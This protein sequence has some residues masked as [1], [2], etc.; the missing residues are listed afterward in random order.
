MGI[1][2]YGTSNLRS[3]QKAGRLGGEERGGTI[4]PVGTRRLLERGGQL[5]NCPCLDLHG[6]VLNCEDKRTSVSNRHEL[7]GPLGFPTF[8]AKQ[9]LGIYNSDLNRC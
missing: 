1:C 8:R 2:S 7:N 5:L 3:L 4:W 9:N 6:V